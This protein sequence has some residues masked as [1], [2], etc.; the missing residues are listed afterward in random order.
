MQSEAG[1]TVASPA[2]GP[3]RRK[4]FLEM[5]KD[6]E[7]T[8]KNQEN[9]KEGHLPSEKSV[10]KNKRR[11]SPH[12]GLFKSNIGEKESLFLPRSHL[13]FGKPGELDPLFYSLQTFQSA[14]S[15]RSEVGDD[16]PSHRSQKE[17]EPGDQNPLDMTNQET[18]TCT[19]CF[20]NL[21]DCVFMNCG[22][23]GLCYECS[24]EVWQKKAKCY[25]CREVLF[26]FKCQ[27]SNWEF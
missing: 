12:S 25:L 26:H 17:Q 7:E 19:I 4:Q 20:E 5:L 21:G 16:K 2:K 14:S 23:G 27:V 8:E 22:H 9:Q 11:H 3:E 18:S 10:L 24:S 15:Y 13:K 6:R 1:Q